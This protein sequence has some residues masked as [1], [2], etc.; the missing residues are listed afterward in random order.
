M[1]VKTD[2]K[3]KILKSS[4]LVKKKFLNL[5]T[6]KLLSTFNSEKE[7]TLKRAP[8]HMRAHTRTHTKNL[9]GKYRVQ[10]KR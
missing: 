10:W 9:K 8:T 4:L 7:N 3:N 6:M 1:R 5:Y 2:V